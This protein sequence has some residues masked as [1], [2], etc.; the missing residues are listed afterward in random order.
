MPLDQ[1]RK[2]NEKESCLTYDGSNRISLKNS[3]PY[4][5]QIQHQMFVTGKLY[6]DFVVFSVRSH[7]GVIMM[8]YQSFLISM[9]DEVIF[10]TSLQKNIKIERTCKDWKILL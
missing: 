8:L 1:S 6:C 10:L 4:I 7:D 5:Q 9:Y 2:A 3:H